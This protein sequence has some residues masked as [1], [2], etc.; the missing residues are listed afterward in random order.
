[1]QLDVY[2]ERGCRSCER[3]TKIARE[4]DETY[5][6]MSVRVIDMADAK[7]S[8]DVFAVP[9]FVLNGEVL[10]LGNPRRDE[11]DRAIESAL[12]SQVD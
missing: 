8:I 4:V 10:S 5:P 3:A 6:Q 2:I 1:M 9:T 7:E 12:D 11:L